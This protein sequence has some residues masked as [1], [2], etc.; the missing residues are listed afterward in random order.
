M[1]ELPEVD[2]I[3]RYLR[4]RLVGRRI[5]RL[6]TPGGLPRGHDAPGASPLKL[7]KGRTIR[8][9]DRR[10]KL[11][12]LRLDQRTLVL[13]LKLTGKCWVRDAESA[14]T[15]STRL[16]LALD[17]GQALDVEDARKLGWSRLLEDEPLEVM[18][19]KNGPEPLD[20]AFTLGFF[21]ELISKKRGR[22]KPLLL[23]P[24]FVAGIGNIYADEVLF[25][26]RLHP[27]RLAS[28]LS[29]REVGALHR[30]IVGSLER[31]VADRTEEVPDQTRV[32]SG[33][34]GASKHIKTRKVF[35][36]A[37]E[38]CPRCGETI[39]RT[40][41]ATRGTYLCPR[42]QPAPGPA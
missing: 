8:A 25:A 12:L 37:G 42:C 21:R 41:V 33:A 28:T 10:A 7:V 22:L 36:R 19:A 35:Q 34:R 16:R 5:T 1:P 39:L 6:E 4:P 9:V 2:H 18:L 24:E 40:V 3:V 15:K 32:G 29:P 38:P 26:A 27:R 11:V 13:H 14:V 20:P 31:A 30:A 23:D 17:D